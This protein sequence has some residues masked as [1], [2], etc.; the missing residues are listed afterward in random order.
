MPGCLDANDPNEPLPR[1]KLVAA[2]MSGHNSDSFVMDKETYMKM[3]EL[4]K[5]AERERDLA[6][7]E[8]AACRQQLKE[9]Q[10][11]RGQQVRCGAGNTYFQTLQKSLPG[12]QA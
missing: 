5:K 3:V 6:V 12:G 2:A 1:A 8:A 11:A 4:M 7:E 10:G 9:L